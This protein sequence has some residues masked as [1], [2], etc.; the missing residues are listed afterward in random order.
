VQVAI[1]V[2]K[3]VSVTGAGH[4][5]FTPITRTAAV[6]IR[7]IT[8]AVYISVGAAEAFAMVAG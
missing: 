1:A 2:L 7:F 5:I 8:A 6:Y 3:A 4:A